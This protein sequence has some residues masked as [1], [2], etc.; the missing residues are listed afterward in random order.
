MSQTSIRIQTIQSFVPSSTEVIWDLCCDHGKIG[1]C[2]AP[3]YEVHFVDQVPVIIEKLKEILSTDIPR[4][5]I[6]LKSVLDLK[7]DNNKKN[8]FILAGIGSHL[9]I[10]MIEHLKKQKPNADFIISTHK[11]VFEL[12]TYLNS[13]NF[14]AH[15]EK[16]VFENNQFY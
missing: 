13:Q 11:N 9:A 14:V 4:D 12:R 5:N 16:L 6:H 10:K 2:F 7:I 3:I 1:E 8:C 15:K